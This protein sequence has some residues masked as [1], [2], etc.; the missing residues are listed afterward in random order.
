MAKFRGIV[1]PAQS[2]KTREV[3]HE[4]LKDMEE[5][6]QHIH[7]VI[8]SNNIL[9][10]EQSTSRMNKELIIHKGTANERHILATSWD[11]KTNKCSREA[12]AKK[13]LSGK[14]ELIGACG[15]GMR[16]AHV[17]MLINTLSNQNFKG[18]IKLWIDE[19]DRVI[20]IW[21]RYAMYLSKTDM[22]ETVVLITATYQKI[23]NNFCRNGIPLRIK[24]LRETYNKETYF[25]CEDCNAVLHDND[26]TSVYYTEY[27]FGLYP[28]M[29]EPG[30]KAFIPAD[31]KVVSH[32]MMADMLFQRGF[33]VFL[34]NGDSKVLRLPDGKTHEIVNFRTGNEEVGLTMRRMYN[35]FE[36]HNYPVAVTGFLCIGRGLTFQSPG[37]VFDYGVISTRG[38]N[39]SELYQIAGRVA[40]NIRQYPDFKPTKLYTSKNVYD[41]ILEEE[42][43]AKNLGY[44][45][46]ENGTEIITQL[47][48]QRACF[49]K[50]YDAYEIDTHIIEHAFNSS[51]PVPPKEVY[52][53][54]KDTNNSYKPHKYNKKRMTITEGKKFWTTKGAIQDLKN[55]VKEIEMQRPTVAL[56]KP[57]KIGESQTRLYH[58]YKNTQDP[59]SLTFVVR[60]VKKMK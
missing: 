8:S 49:K 59:S 57:L 10:M 51:D 19:A 12:L 48:V 46:Y 50:E 32:N 55:V 3:I 40:G 20:N 7:L 35:T 43:I 26:G 36:C 39:R 23:A 24:P 60:T 42:Q 18:K 25:G 14:I 11:S 54:L 53:H 15:N 30:V 2:G 29:T 21:W 9:L 58:G 38:C 52:A 56:A 16:M 45:A 1:K 5:N 34:L 44:I 28:E 4:I 22:I 31:I 41:K 6:T 13:C 37:F 33:A 27:L 47:D 17:I